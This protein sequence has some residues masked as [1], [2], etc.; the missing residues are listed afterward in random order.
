MHF[1]RAVG[2]AAALF[3]LALAAGW[4]RFFVRGQLA[5]APRASGVFLMPAPAAA[6]LLTAKYTEAAADVVWTQT[7]V[8]HGGQFEK[9]LEPR[10]LHAYVDA[11]TTLD[12]YFRAPY[13]WGGFAITFA[14]FSGVPQPADV[15][16][17]VDLLRGGLAR[18]PDDAELNG[19]LG[20]ILY[21]ELPRWIDDPEVVLRSKVEG[22]EYLRKQARL[23]GG[24]P[25]MALSAA[26]ALEKL[27]LDDL[28]AQLLEESALSVGDPTV[29]PLIMA[30]LARLRADAD[31]ELLR[32]AVDTLAGTA[33]REAPYLPL[34]PFLLLSSPQAQARMAEG[35]VPDD[36]WS[37]S[38]PASR[39]R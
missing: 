36:P 28:A 16:F 31:I 23:G 12:P 1:L 37:L 38:R 25:W 11:L 29:R 32:Q 10:Y 27:N 5:G 22:A 9:Q 19:T 20:Y 21:Y 33:M 7:L 2:I 39:R 14:H 18:F 34:I 24:P 35:L 6:R 3:F 30:R 8:Y 17:A 13:N 15:L 4:A 26:T